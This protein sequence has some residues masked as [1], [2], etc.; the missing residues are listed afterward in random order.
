VLAL[1]DVPR[2]EPTLLTRVRPQRD[3]RSEHEDEPREPDQVDERLH[4]DAEEDR[5]V[6]VDL[7]GDHEQILARERIG[8]D[9]DLIRDLLLDAVGVLPRLDR[10]ER[11]AAAADVEHRAD[12]RRVRAVPLGQVAVR[13]PVV[14]D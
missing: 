8:A 5:A 6:V 1:G 12:L 14:T 10:A 4:E 2:R 7:L 13:Q 9:P 11:V 3:Q